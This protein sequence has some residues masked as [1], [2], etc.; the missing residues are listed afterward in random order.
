MSPALK[1]ALDRCRTLLL[2]AVAGGA[3]GMGGTAPAAIG[4]QSQA[5]TP[6]EAAA[7]SAAQRAR[8]PE[9]Y[10][11]YLELFPIGPH[12]EEAFRLLIE[13]SFQRQPVPQLVDLEPALGPGVP[14]RTRVVAAADLALY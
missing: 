12:A 6:A 10:Q 7:W 8:T 9:A 14:E 4:P 3:A 13:R 11:R 1:A 5:V 2:A